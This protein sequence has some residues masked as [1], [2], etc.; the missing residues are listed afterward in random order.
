MR[1]KYDLY[2]CSDIFMK[3]RI[4][5]Y[6]FYSCFLFLLLLLSCC[7]RPQIASLPESGAAVAGRQAWSRLLEVNSLKADA[8]LSW[9]ATGGEH[10][11]YRVR[12]FLAAPERLK[13]QWLTPWGS[14]AGQLIIAEGRFWLSNA[15]EKQ[16]WHGRAKDIDKLLQQPGFNNQGADFQTVATR[17]F[18][19]WPLLF[20]TPAADD[21]NF[22]GD[23][24][25]EYFAYGVGDELS[26][27]KNVITA[28]GS[29]LNFRLFELKELSDKQLLPQAV[30]ILSKSGRIGI[31]LRNFSLQPDF[32]VQTFIYSL[33]KFNLHECL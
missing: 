9:R 17:F 33:K 32:A 18:R 26:F 21:R 31:K 12:L 8:I 4:V 25:I 19:Y 1:R 28:D 22:S 16:T 11:K 20:S 3:L 2:R 10:G 6:R 5:H 7:T 15:R 30:E 29:N 23:V 13:I 24:V 27:A 14:V